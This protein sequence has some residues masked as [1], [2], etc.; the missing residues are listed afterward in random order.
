MLMDLLGRKMPWA[1]A[2]TWTDPSYFDTILELFNLLQA[3]IDQLQLNWVPG[4]GGVNLAAWPQ[5]WHLDSKS[6][7]MYN[8]VLGRF[9]FS[10]PIYKFQ[11]E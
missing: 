2:G 6:S 7:S 3:F 11:P 1:A 4:S 10:I 8:T 5:V 9:G